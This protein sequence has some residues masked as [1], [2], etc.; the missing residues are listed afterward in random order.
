M[1][2]PVA[3]AWRVLRLR[4]EERTP[5]GANI[6]NKQQRTTDN[7][8]CF[9]LWFGRGLKKFHSFKTYH[10]TNLSGRPSTRYELILHDSDRWRAILNAVMNPRLP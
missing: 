10:V 6:L 7:V 4:M 3:T 5:Y 8:C 1:W 9:I 2:V